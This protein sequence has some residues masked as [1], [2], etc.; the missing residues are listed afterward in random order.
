MTNNDNQTAVPFSPQAS[1]PDLEEQ[2]LEEITGTGGIGDA[3]ST[4][5]HKCEA[6]FVV[7]AQPLTPHRYDAY[8]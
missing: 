6:G 1:A 4:P 3:L 5:G 7:L 2:A 8:L